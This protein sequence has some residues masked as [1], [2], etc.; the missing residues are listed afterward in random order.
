MYG[1]SEPPVSSK[2]VSYKEKAWI[3]LHSF[4]NA[5]HRQI[6]MQN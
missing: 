4:F 6:L 1:D 3:L 5:F 2:R